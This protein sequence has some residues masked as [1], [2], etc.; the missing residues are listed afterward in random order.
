MKPD[1][2]RHHRVKPKKMQ[3][4]VYPDHPCDQETSLNAEILDISRSGIRI[5]LSQPAQTRVNEKIKIT[6]I[7]PESGEP[8]SVHG[9]LKHQ[10]LDGEYGVH[11]TDHAEGSIDDMLFECIKLNDLIMLIKSA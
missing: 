8:F 7:L 9:I 1:R 5:K 3:V 10:H 2:R 11:Y 6:M 4:A